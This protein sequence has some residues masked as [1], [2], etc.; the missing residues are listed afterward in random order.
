M[1][2]GMFG[3]DRLDSKSPLKNPSWPISAVL[4]SVKNET[5]AV[6]DAFFA[7]TG[8]FCEILLK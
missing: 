6:R 4:A 3:R 1:V 8:H 7:A 5:N 2:F